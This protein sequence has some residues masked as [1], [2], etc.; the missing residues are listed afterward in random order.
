MAQWIIRHFYILFFEVILA[1]IFIATFVNAL[2]IIDIGFDIQKPQIIERLLMAQN[3]NTLLITVLL[4]FNSFWLLYI[5][6]S[7]L[8]L[9]GILKNIDYNLGRRRSDKNHQDD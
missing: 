6:S 3:I 5:F 7:I 1:G 8:K 9:R 2:K 4:L